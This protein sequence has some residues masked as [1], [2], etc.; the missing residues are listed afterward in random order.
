MITEEAVRKE[1]YQALLERKTEYDGI[2][3]AGIKTTGVFCH[4]TCPARKPKYDNCQF[5]ETAEEALLSGFRPCKRCRPLSFPREIPETVQKMVDLVEAQ[6]EKRWKDSDF[7][8]LGIHAATARRQFKKVYGM[9]FVQ[10]ARARRMG[11]AMKTIKNGEKIIDTQ[12]DMGYESTSGFHDAFTKIMGRKPVLSKAMKV[13]YADWVDTVLGPM[14]SIADDEFLYLLEFVDRRGLER[15]IE[16][17]RNRLSAQII[18]GKTA[19]SEQIKRELDLYFKGVLTTFKTP[20]TLMGSDFQKDVWHQLQL[21]E[22]GQTSTYKELAEK[23]DNPKAIRAVGTA[24]GANQLAIIIPCHR[25]IQTGGGLGGYAGGLERKRW[26]LNHERKN[27][28]K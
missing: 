6:P 20:I 25:V 3:F 11:I 1:F 28:M 23:I 18:P 5:Y 8:A 19:V 9:T 24:N 16:R 15:E 12:L 13:L 22:P 27:R 7:S 14:M 17:L 10:Y 2:F 21:I 26:L 4:A